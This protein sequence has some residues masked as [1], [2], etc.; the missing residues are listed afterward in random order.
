MLRL[1]QANCPVLCR[2][3]NRHFMGIITPLSPWTGV[4][5]V[6]P[7]PESHVARQTVYDP[8]FKAASYLVSLSSNMAPCL[9]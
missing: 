2:L 9:W 6:R 5:T 8:R 7:P 3:H 1:C 4:I